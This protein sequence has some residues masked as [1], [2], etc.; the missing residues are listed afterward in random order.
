[1]I[2][3]LNNNFIKS[4]NKFLPSGFIDNYNT[5]LVC[6]TKVVIFVKEFTSQTF[7]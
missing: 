2:Q 6:P 7:I 5:R 1:M 4:N 3:L